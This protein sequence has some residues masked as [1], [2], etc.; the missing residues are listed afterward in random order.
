MDFGEFLAWSRQVRRERS[1]VTP[2][3]ETRIGRALASIRPDPCPSFD[4]D[5]HRCD[6]ARDWCRVR[7][8]SPALA[9]RALVCRGVRHALKTLFARIAREDGTVVLPRD[10]YPV[11]WTLASHAGVRAMGVPTF[12]HFD[13]QRVLAEADRPGAMHVLLPFPLKLHGRAWSAGEVEGATRWLAGCPDRRLLLDGVYSFGGPLGPALEALLATDQVTY[14]DSLSKGWLHE[15]VFGTA[16]VPTQ[17]LAGHLPA[18]RSDSP[19]REELH[20]ARALLS[21]H[22]VFPVRLA[23]ELDRLRSGLVAGLARRGVDVRD[24]T[25]GYLLAVGLDASE[26]LEEHGIVAIPASVFG[27]DVPGWS[28]ASALP[29]VAP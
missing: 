24:A 21:T 26:L 7:G 9:K 1:D 15:Q 8:L 20:V 23:S 2:A 19:S 5:V 3:C 16:I 18:F 28:I 4:G 27:S 14:L 6:L 17:D 10:V 13:V 25:R 12:P 22:E 11:Y 29:V